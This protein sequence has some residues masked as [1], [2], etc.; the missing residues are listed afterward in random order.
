MSSRFPLDSRASHGGL[1]KRAETNMADDLFPDG[2]GSDG[3]A[4]TESKRFRAL[5]VPAVRAVERTQGDCPADLTEG[6]QR[7]PARLFVGRTGGSY[8]T[9]THLALKAA[10]AAALD[11]V[12]CD[13]EPE[14]DWGREFVARHEIVMAASAAESKREYLLR[15]ESGR[16]LSECSRRL[17]RRTC[18]MDSDV[19]FVLGDGLSANALKSQA[20]RLLPGLIGGC[21]E[22]GWSV[23]RPVFVRHCRVGI[24]NDFGESLRGRVVAL[25]VGERPGWGTS[26]SLSIYFAFAPRA[27]HTDAHRNLISNIHERGVSSEGAIARSLDLIARLLEQGRSGVDIKERLPLD[28]GGANRMVII[29]PAESG[30]TSLP[31]V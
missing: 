11:A 29:E 20:P 25:L 4:I 23:G 5:G 13:F 16:K 9:S 30:S 14:R 26:E 31:K 10:H 7:T 28:T 22:R 8:R 3:S 21:R 19:Q 12:Y 24:L 17:V 6:L 15:P 18:P 27:G 1:L 2:L